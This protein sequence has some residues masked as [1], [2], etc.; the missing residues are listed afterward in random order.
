MPTQ[1]FLLNQWA[2]PKQMGVRWRCTL[3]L[4]GKGT[5]LAGLGTCL[6]GQ[7]ATSDEDAD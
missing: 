4:M 7:A 1:R 5:C 6:A 3:P 2:P